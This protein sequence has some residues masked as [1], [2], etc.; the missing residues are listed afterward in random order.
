M[1]LVIFFP[2][3]V[4]GMGYE[5]LL[6]FFRGLVEFG[7]EFFLVVGSSLLN[8]ITALISLLVIDLNGFYALVSFLVG[9]CI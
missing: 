3:I 9:K 5:A 4:H 8:S 6:F 2:F 7:N 1:T